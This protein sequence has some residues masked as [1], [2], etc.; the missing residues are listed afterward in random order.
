[1]SRLN[2][3]DCVMWNW[4]CVDCVDVVVGSSVYV[5]ESD[6]RVDSDMKGVVEESLGHGTHV[7]HI[8]DKIES[9]SDW[10]DD[11]TY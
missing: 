4:N 7:D 8:F 11:V 5:E 2:C 3:N 1:M 10:K 6:L 9:K